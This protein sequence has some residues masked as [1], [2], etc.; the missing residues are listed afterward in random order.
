MVNELLSGKYDALVVTAGALCNYLRQ[1]ELRMSDVSAIVLDECHHVTGEHDYGKLLDIVARCPDH[2]RPRVLGLTASPFN[3]KTEGKA[4][5]KLKNLRSAFFNAE[6]YRP[7]VTE[8]STEGI[9][10]YP[11]SL[12][13]QQRNKQA[14]LVSKICTPLN[15]LISIYRIYYPDLLKG[16]GSDSIDANYKRHWCRIVNI[17]AEAHLRH[18]PEDQKQTAKVVAERVRDLVRA[19][20]DNY[21]LGPAFVTL[22]GRTPDAAAIASAAAGSDNLPSE[23]NPAAGL[24]NQ[25]LTLCA[26]VDKYGAGSSTLVFVDTRYTAELLTQYLMV[27]FSAFNC[28]K[29]IG[30][31][32]VNGMRWRGGAGQG[33]VLQAFR[34]G[35]TKLIVC[36][37]VLE[38]GKTIVDICREKCN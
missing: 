29:V 14:E 3:A 20:E 1:E 9:E 2:L 38:E 16:S 31:G 13:V 4:A 34:S 27:R 11:V 12:T 25:L 21:L 36:T 23:D 22:D 32:G 26:L 15:S 6:V 7:H 8:Q 19:L 18:L 33:A 28:T 37:R 10:R 5:T 35:D 17:S 30:Q 24:S